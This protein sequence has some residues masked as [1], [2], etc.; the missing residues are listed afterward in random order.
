M[1]LDGWVGWIYAD[2]LLA[3]TG[4]ITDSKGV[5]IGRWLRSL[6]QKLP[7]FVKLGGITGTQLEYEGLAPT[8]GAVQQPM[9]MTVIFYTSRSY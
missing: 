6:A 4:W 3:K 7:L 9:S 2:L 8:I 1:P 5:T